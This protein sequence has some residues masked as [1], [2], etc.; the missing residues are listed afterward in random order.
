MR[1]RLFA[2]I[3][4]FL[5]SAIALFAAEMALRWRDDDTRWLIADPDLGY[6]LNP[7]LGGVNSLGILHAE[8]APHQPETLVR[9]LL[10]GDS[11]AA[12]LDGFVSLVRDGLTSESERPIEVIN[13]AIPGYTT[14]QQRVLLERDLEPFGADLVL[15]Q[16]CLND[17][18]RFLHQ[19]G[20]GGRWVIISRDYERGSEA[21]LWSTW[22]PRSAILRRIDWRLRAE[23]R[24]QRDR[25]RFPWRNNEFGNAWREDTWRD[26]EDHLR[27]IRDS[28]ARMGARFGLVTVPYEPQLSDDA[29]ASDRSYTLFPQRK[30]AMIAERLSFPHLDLHASFLG[31]REKTLY[32]DR[33]HLSKAGHALAASELLS[34]IEREGLLDVARSE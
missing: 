20:E 21:G 29:L 27:A 4:L 19:L 5:S 11:V 26:Q 13:A 12:D 15:L 8:L 25:V 14:Y 31:E 24:A 2:S 3:V 34:F 6:K 7:T 17:N 33:I 10:L 28:A 32:T 16:Y 1:K 22:A 9:V 18:H 30:L 23:E